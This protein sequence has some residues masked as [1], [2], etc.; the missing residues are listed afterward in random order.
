LAP[1]IRYHNDKFYI[2]WGDPDFGI[3]AITA[4]N[5]EGPWSE[6]YLVHEAKGWMI[7]ALLG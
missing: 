1:S 7:P 3:Y 4:D 2:Y 6:P 5:V